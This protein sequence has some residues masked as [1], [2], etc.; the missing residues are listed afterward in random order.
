M[1]YGRFFIFNVRFD[2]V[3]ILKIMVSKSP[4]NRSVLKIIVI[5]FTSFSLY[6]PIH[7]LVILAIFNFL[8]GNLNSHRKYGHQEFFEKSR[9]TRVKNSQKFWKRCKVEFLI[10]ALIYSPYSNFST[11]DWLINLFSILF[12]NHQT[13]RITTLKI[14]KSSRKLLTITFSRLNFH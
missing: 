4:K 2:W 9:M 8:A 7:A 11:L 6:L 14:W 10:L 13:I 3:G 1:F 5:Y 12:S